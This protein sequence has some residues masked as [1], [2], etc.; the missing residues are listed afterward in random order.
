MPDLSVQDNSFVEMGG[1]GTYYDFNITSVPSVYILWNKS[2]PSEE[3]SD[4]DIIRYAAQSSAFAFLN[5]PEEDIY[6]AEDGDEICL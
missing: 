1:F 4:E 2:V 5:D 3:A 6:T